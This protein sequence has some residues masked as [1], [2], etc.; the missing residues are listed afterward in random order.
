VLITK[1]ED[2][3]SM[4]IHHNTRKNVN[5]HICC[6]KSSFVCPEG[7]SL[8]EAKCPD[9]EATQ[10]ASDIAGVIIHTFLK[11]DTLQLFKTSFLLDH[12]IIYEAQ[13]TGV[14]HD[15]LK[16]LSGYHCSEY[17]DDIKPGALDQNGIL[18]QDLQKL[19]FSDSL[20]DLVITQD[21]FEHI[22]EPEKAFAEIC[23]ILK[24]G[25][26]HIFTIPYHEGK[27][28]LRRIT[29]EE[30]KRTILYPEV[31]HGD[32]LRERGAAVY[33][34]FGEDFVTML[35]SQGFV[36][37]AFL[38]GKW[39]DYNEIPTILDENSYETYLKY[40]NTNDLCRFFKY[41]SW[42]FRSQ[43]REKRVKNYA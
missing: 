40:Y 8:R 26:F 39:Y 14:I 33:T 32:P 36:T 1:I 42:V 13:S 35:E 38:C 28:T 20:F 10:R 24:P 27:K 25:G 7:V 41:N 29:F 9:C 18:C 4:K 5:C 16:N 31:Y 21:V 22:Q 15:C 6:C 43:K 34:D 19:T 12:L 17:F 30:G 37:E 23:R 3:Y 2:E 11:D